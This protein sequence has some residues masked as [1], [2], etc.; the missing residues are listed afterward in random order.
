MPPLNRA[1][2]ELNYISILV[3]NTVED[4]KYVLKNLIG[5]AIVER[6]I[7]AHENQE[8]FMVF[9]LMPLMPAFPAELSTKEAATAR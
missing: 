9:V 1:L 8:K 3:T 7:R 5:K 6:I 2:K 4:D